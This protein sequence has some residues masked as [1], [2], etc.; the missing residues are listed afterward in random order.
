LHIDKAEYRVGDT[1]RVLLSKVV[2]PARALVTTERDRVFTSQWVG[3]APGRREIKIP[4]LPVHRSGFWVSVAAYYGGKTPSETVK[5]GDELAGPGWTSDRIFVKVTWREKALAISLAADK[6]LYAPGDE[7]SLSCSIP[8]LHSCEH[9]VIVWAED[10]GVLSLTGYKTPDILEAMYYDRNHGV[11]LSDT[12]ETLLKPFEFMNPAIKIPLPHF[13]KGGA[14]R[15]G[16]GQTTGGELSKDAKTR[17]RFSMRPLFLSSVHADAQGRAIVRFRLPD[18]LTKFRIMA[19]AAD[20]GGR[21]GAADTSIVVTKPLFLRP[22]LPQCLRNRDTIRIGGLLENRTDATDTAS[23]SLSGKGLAFLEPSIARLEVPAKGRKEFFAAAVIDG[24]AD[25][26]RI[27]FSAVSPKDSDAVEACVPVTPF[28]FPKSVTMCGTAD[29]TKREKIKGPLRHD[30]GRST[31]SVEATNTIVRDLEGSLAYLET[32][33]YDCAEQM[34][35]KIL[36]L[37]LCKDVFKKK[38]AGFPT[39]SLIREKVIAYLRGLPEYATA[40]RGYGFSYWKG[41]VEESPSLTAYVLFALHRAMD[42]GYGVENDMLLSCYNGLYRYLRDPESRKEY[43]WYARQCAVAAVLSE[44]SRYGRLP[45]QSARRLDSLVDALVPLHASGSLFAKIT[46][47]RIL[48]NRSGPAD[49]SREIAG[50]IESNLVHEPLYAYFEEPSTYASR[51]WHQTPVRTTALALQTLLE[52][53]RELPAA[54]K[55]ARWLLLKKAGEGHWT[56]TQDN[57]YALWALSTYARF[58]EPPAT[59][60]DAAL[61]LDGGKVL[62]HS[63]SG[64][65]A[66]ERFEWQRPFSAIAA[67]PEHSLV[68]E[69][70]GSG[71]LYY[72]IRMNCL[73]LDPVKP[74]DAGLRIEKNY[75]TLDGR[76][77]SPDSLRYREIV[78]MTTAVA[79]PRERQYVVVDD[80]IPAGCE[81]INEA[82]NTVEQAVKQGIKKKNRDFFFSWK[83]WNHFEY[84]KEGCRVYATRLSPGRHQ[85]TYAVRPIARGSFHLPP[86]YAQEMYSPEVYGRN[87]EGTAT[88]R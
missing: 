53:G 73:P 26:C 35:S 21:F 65:T 85:F 14:L 12:R 22:L 75:T 66:E 41:G 44:H 82:F 60:F 27:L 2:R 87:G 33:P 55:I 47:L 76:P 32:Y 4:V 8:Q 69:K 42:C 83:T 40:W 68:F 11:S 1:V 61:L 78:L 64:G 17:R 63:F 36:P 81:I 58:K 59:A 79:T 10:E 16:E 80:P 38:A 52:T 54:D 20:D 7:V 39:D 88:V 3:I 74:F 57:A 24:I 77:I 50:Y 6:P 86:A 23:V 37:L 9:E 46:I 28:R 56:T 48:R 72:T 51:S 31:L 62:G 84:R 70:S 13:V 25:T 34:T 45:S 5:K 71:S 67:V 19:V 49:L 15:L 43:D 30:L 18:N 29:K